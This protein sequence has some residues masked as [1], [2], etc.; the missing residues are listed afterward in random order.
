MPRVVL[1]LADGFEEVEAVAVVDVLRRAG[2]ETV[3]AGLHEGFAS[4]ARGIRILPDALIDDV[5]AEDFDMIVLPGGQPGADN[6]NADKRVRQL[7]AEFR[8]KGKS[9]A[10]ICAAPYVLAEAGLLEG[11]RV[12]AYPGYD[13]KLRGGLYEDKGVVD[14]GN[15]ITAMGAG[16]ALCF[17][18]AI[19]SKLSGAE[20]AKKIK[21]AMIIRYD[22]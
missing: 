1:L 7:I 20:T 21:D 4:S 14:D 5:R 15:V 6:L 9:A 3:I 19:V 13:K 18:L 2:I 22:C 11:K 12:T 17:G 8:E 10:A 16:T